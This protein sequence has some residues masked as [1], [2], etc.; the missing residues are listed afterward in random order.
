MIVK[1][2][3]QWILYT[4]DGSKRLGTFRTKEAALKR[5]KQIKFFEKLGK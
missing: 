3:N 5:E 1:R 4:K 2:G